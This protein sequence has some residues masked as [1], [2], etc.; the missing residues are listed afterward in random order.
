[1]VEGA[2][3]SVESPAFV[4]LA[5]NL[6]PAG[7]ATHS[8]KIDMTAPSAATTL[9]GRTERSNDWYTTAPAWT[10]DGATA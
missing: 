7:A 3:V 9:D 2:A 8:F 6:A 5:G 1:M 10:T 4:D